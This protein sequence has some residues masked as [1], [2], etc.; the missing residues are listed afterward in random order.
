MTKHILSTIFIAAAVCTLAP[1]RASAVPRAPV[2]AARAQAAAL[3]STWNCETTQ[4]NGTVHEETDTIE[5][6]GHWLRG[7][8]RDGTG[9][10]YDYYLGYAHGHWIYIQVSALQGSYFVGTSTGGP[11]GALNGSRWRVVF[12]QG[13]DAY[14]FSETPTQFTIDFVGLRQ[15]CNKIAQPPAPPPPPTLQCSTRA[16]G[17]ATAFE[18]YASIV[19]LGPH[20]WQGV[21]SEAP[22]GGRAIYAYDIFNAGLRRVAVAVNGSTGD[23]AIATSYLAPT[24]DN[25]VWTVVYP[26]EERGFSFRNV[27]PNNALPQRFTLVFADGYQTCSPF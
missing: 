15:V 19:P 4:A 18:S 14:S 7:M 10:L 12:P 8:A 11:H 9:P 1:G 20:W 25:T 27:W 2:H 3:L 23:Y 13:R 26:T 21:G 6:M 22:G 24:L 17:S 5:P 16:T